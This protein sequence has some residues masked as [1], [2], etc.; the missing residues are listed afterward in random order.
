[1]TKEFNK[2]VNFSDFS[3]S[4]TFDNGHGHSKG[5]THSNNSVKGLDDKFAVFRVGVHQRNR[6]RLSYSIKIIYDEFYLESVTEKKRTSLAKKAGV[7]VQKAI[8]DSK[9]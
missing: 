9:K 7:L 4:R 8:N 2:G 6:G 3:G 1:M 5:Y